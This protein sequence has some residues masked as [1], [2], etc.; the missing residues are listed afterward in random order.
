LTSAELAENVNDVSPPT[1]WLKDVRIKSQVDAAVLAAAVA[2][3][4]LVFAC[5]ML[6]TTFLHVPIFALL[7]ALAVG[8]FVIAYRGFRQAR[9]SYN[10]VIADNPDDLASYQSDN[11]TKDE[12]ISKELRQYRAA[13]Y[14]L[15]A[16]MATYLLTT[17]MRVHL[18]EPAML[19][20]AVTYGGLVALN[21]ALLKRAWKK[22]DALPTADDKRA[23]GDDAI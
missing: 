20:V 19:A 13:N 12:R 14:L 2:T 5:V 15:L 7:L 6:A 23:S 1:R 4:L 18:P 8:A 11:W 21:F 16:A 10:M 17:L 3:I 22:F 9:R